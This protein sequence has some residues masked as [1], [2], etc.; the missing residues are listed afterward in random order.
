MP[1]KQP[2]PIISD[3]SLSQ[4]WIDA[5]TG[6]SSLT[7]PLEL[8]AAARFLE[9]M[10]A[11]L[12]AGA[13]CESEPEFDQACRN[14][15]WAGGSGEQAV[16][17]LAALREAIQTVLPNATTPA[18]NAVD[19]LLDRAIVRVVHHTTDE[20]QRDA[21]IDPLT[22]LLN[23]RALLRNLEGEAGRATRLGQTFSVMFVDI[24]GLKDVNDRHGHRAGDAVLV[25]LAEAITAVLRRGDTAYRIGG[26]EFV[27]ILPGTTFGSVEPF[28]ARLEAAGAPAFSWGAA[29]Y[30]DDAGSI[31]DVLDKAD[32]QLIAQR[33]MRR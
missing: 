9:A 22:G 5:C 17:Q 1:P 33:R 4:A 18:R 26:D 3:R 29:S 28:V 8:D 15:A 23:R 16:R 6:D 21:L 32:N 11:A 2:L 20:L 30:P 19:R 14:F 25:Q 12:H 27:V 24:D 7:E 13:T 31:D 10:A